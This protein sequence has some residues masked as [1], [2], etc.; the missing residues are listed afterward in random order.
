[1]ARLRGRYDKAVARGETSNRLR[2]WH[3]GSR[4]GYVLATRLSDKADQVWLFTTVF[5]VPWTNN[6][7]EQ[8]LKSPNLAV[9]AGFAE[10]AV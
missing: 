4:L 9:S 1:M 8:A 7:S 6:A 10:P 5:S 3:K 2:D